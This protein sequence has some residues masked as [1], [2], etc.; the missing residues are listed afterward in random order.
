MKVDDRFSLSW[1]NPQLDNPAFECRTCGAL[2][3][4]PERHNEWHN[5]MENQTDAMSK[6][7]TV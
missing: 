5:A 4:S 3:T 6:R 7:F 1:Q 2:T